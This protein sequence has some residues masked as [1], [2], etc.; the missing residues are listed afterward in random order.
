MIPERSGL[1]IAGARF[2]VLPDYTL[3]ESYT[4]TGSV[5]HIDPTV[6]DDRGFRSFF[7]YR[8]PPRHIKGVVLECQEV[9]SSSGTMHIR[10][11]TNRSSREVHGHGHA[12]IFGQVSDLVSFQD[13]AGSSEIRMDLAHC[14]PLA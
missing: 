1:E 12:V 10:H 14:V 5:R 7:H 6:V 8:G 13:A 9:P 3:V 4:K 2:Q 11:A